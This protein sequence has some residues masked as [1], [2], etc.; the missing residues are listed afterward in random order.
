MVKKTISSLDFR[1]F[2]SK[3]SRRMMGTMKVVVATSAGFCRGV[4]RAVDRARKLAREGKA[5]IFTDGPLIHNDEMMESLKAQGIRE[6]NSPETLDSGVLLVRAHGIPPDRRAWLSG[7]NAT[8]VDATCPD[9]ARIQGLI[10]QHARRGFHIVIFG[11][12]GHAEVI[13]LTGYAE[14]S[15]HVVT[16]PHDVEALPD[17][18][19]VCVV[20]QSTQFPPDYEDVVAAIKRRFPNACILDTICAS[21]RNRQQD[22]LDIAAAVD[23]IVVVGG[24][25]SANTVRLVKLAET[26]KPTFHIQTGGEIRASDYRGYRSVGLTAG[27]S[28]PCFIID[29]VRKRLEAL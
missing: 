15:G 12:P 11:D 28:T 27:A 13:G 21:T 23:A 1:V 5:S 29:D 3:G 19:P 4:Q 20:S 18:D 16:S 24:R 26:L 17:M 6:T 8:I 7:L 22:L 2:L 14:G 9:V 10:R 25:H